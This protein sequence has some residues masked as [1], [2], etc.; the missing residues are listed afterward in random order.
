MMK[1]AVIT[2]CITKSIVLSRRC[3]N[4][5]GYCDFH[6]QAHAP[7][8]SPKKLDQAIRAALQQGATELEV[9]GGEGVGTLKEIASASRYYG[10]SN[11]LHYLEQAFAMS[12][13]S[14]GRPGLLAVPNL[15]SFSQ[16][17]LERLKNWVPCLKLFFE[18]SDP[19]LMMDLAH[20]GAPGK[21]PE[22]RLQNIIDAG[23]ARIPVTTG[24]L[25]GI[26]ETGPS[27]KRTLAVLAEVHRRYGHL[28]NVI[29]EPFEPQAGTKMA[30]WPACP[31]E[32]LLE[33]I[34]LAR[35]IFGLEFPLTLRIFKRQHL[36]DQALESGINDFGE[37]CL[38]TSVE[39]N[40]TLLQRL[41]LIQS[42]CSARG[43]ELQERLPVFAAY[44]NEEWLSP[45]LLQLVR[46]WQYPANEAAVS[47]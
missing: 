35:Q 44:Q 41:A 1:P 28:Q 15:G 5:C 3:V 31:D 4:H 11:Y 22:K 17:D 13:H 30:D 20:E 12:A 33:T 37:I 6:T 18:S 46:Q 8:P 42:Y 45:S 39:E 9:L 19:A 43:I 14:N 32:L 7:L 23:A 26:G 21:A 10:F 38:G 34:A 40:A 24:I 2:Y 47:M 16:G 25:I 29:L 36:L 27:R